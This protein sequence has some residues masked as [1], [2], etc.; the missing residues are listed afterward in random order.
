MPALFT[1]NQS[2]LAPVWQSPRFLSLET[3][4]DFPSIQYQVTDSINNS[5]LE[6]HA[7][8]SRLTRDA[9]DMD[10][11]TTRGTSHVAPRYL[12][13]ETGGEFRMVQYQVTESVD[14]SDLEIHWLC[15]N[16]Q[17]G[18]ESLEN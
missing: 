8:Q 9:V 2:L 3:G 6:I 4:G 15:A 17:F 18:G 13:L 16:V 7:I 11:P 1:L 10:N 5:D 12:M 14:S